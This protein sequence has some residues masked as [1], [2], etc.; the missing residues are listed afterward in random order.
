[1]SLSEQM[2]NIRTQGVVGANSDPNSAPANTLLHCAPAQVFA[3]EMGDEQGRRIRTVVY[4]I[5]GALYADPN[6]EA[7]AK[8]LRPI[9]EATWLAKQLREAIAAQDRTVSLPKTD[10]V[11]L[12]GG[13][14]R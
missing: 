1:M 6:G 13:G 9:A 8:A 14:D 7:W 5:G 10:N 2:K 4:K 12:F 11:D 3:I